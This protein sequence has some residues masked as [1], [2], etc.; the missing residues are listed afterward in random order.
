MHRELQSSK[1]HLPIPH[2]MFWVESRDERRCLN[3]LFVG[4]KVTKSKSVPDMTQS[5]L[6]SLYSLLWYSCK[7]LR[8]LLKLILHNTLISESIFLFWL[9]IK[10]KLKIFSSSCLWTIRCL[11]LSA[12]IPSLLHTTKPSQKSWN[13]NEDFYFL[14]G[15]N[16]SKSNLS[17]AIL[18]ALSQYTP[19]HRQL[20]RQE[21][22]W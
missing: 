15:F 8:E 14:M 21:R 6:H 18:S 5:H 20:G 22:L 16:C 1:N 19:K 17:I 13:E 4:G 2:N 9:P 12:Q 7:N 3:D 11:P 10:I